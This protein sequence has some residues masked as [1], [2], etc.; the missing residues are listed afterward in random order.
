[1]PKRRFAAHY[2]HP[3]NGAQHAAYLPGCTYELPDDVAHAAEAA[4]ALVETRP[5][6]P[7]KTQVVA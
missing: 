7:K 6:K 5:I 3:L 2:D 1:M 4:G